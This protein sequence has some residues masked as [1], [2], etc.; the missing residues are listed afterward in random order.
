VTDYLFSKVYKRVNFLKNLVIEVQENI[1]A[2]KNQKVYFPLEI[3]FKKPDS[4]TILSF[5]LWNRHSWHEAHFSFY[6]YPLK[7]KTINSDPLDL[8]NTFLQ[9]SNNQVEDYWFFPALMAG[10]LQRSSHSDS[11]TDE[12]F[13]KNNLSLDL[14][15]SSSKMQGI[16]LPYQS[17]GR[18]ISS[19]YNAERSSDHRNV[20]FDITSL[21][22]AV[23]IGYTAFMLIKRGKL[24]L[25][26]IHQFSDNP[27]CINFSLEKLIENNYRKTVINPK[28]YLYFKGSVSLKEI[29]LS[30]E[31]LEI[32]R[33]YM[34]FYS[35]HHGSARL[36]EVDR[37][38]DL[39]KRISKRSRLLFQWDGKS[40]PSY[41]IEN[42]IRFL[43]LGI[44]ETS[45]DVTCQNLVEFLY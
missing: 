3:S 11:T 17:I 5:I 21:Y 39:P 23:M 32:L 20:F 43:L 30:N 25:Y 37:T 27:T 8:F 24:S 38:H 45:E 13:K 33:N 42:C 18:T 4:S 1:D 15:W 36:Y 2:V 9:F 12:Y 22:N 7:H 16:L 40:Y 19:A 14:F 10:A 6:K 44:F 28:A 31:I 34:V 26:N 29:T 35:N 41:I